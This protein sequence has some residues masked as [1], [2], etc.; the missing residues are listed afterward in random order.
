MIRQQLLVKAEGLL[1]VAVEILTVAAGADTENVHIEAGQANSNFAGLFGVFQAELFEIL[2]S[3]VLRQQFHPGVLDELFILDEAEC[4]GADVDAVEL[5]VKHAA[6]QR[7]VADLAQV[8]LTGFHQ[9]VQVHQQAL[10]HISLNAGVVLPDHIGQIAGRGQRVHLDPV[11]VPAQ[12]FGL[13]LNAGGLGEHIAKLQ[14]EGIGDFGT[15]PCDAQGLVRRQRG[16]AHAAQQ[17]QSQKNRKQFFH[18]SIPPCRFCLARFPSR[19]LS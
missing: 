16:R 15:P 8:D 12:I 3:R 1:I 14:L 6:G 4:I 19:R 2:P 13:V 11:V 10:V 9:L 7:A 18:E 17:H 5:A